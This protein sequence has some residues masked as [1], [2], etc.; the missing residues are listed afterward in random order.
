MLIDFERAKWQ[1]ECHET[2]T[3][4]IVG[5][6]CLLSAPKSVCEILDDGNDTSDDTNCIQQQNMRLLH[7]HEMCLDHMNI[8]LMFF[9]C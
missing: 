8:Y 5:T 3:R 9:R 1:Q 4:T 6:T 2:I 7:F